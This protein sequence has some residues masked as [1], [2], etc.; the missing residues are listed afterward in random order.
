MLI[1][2][3]P[4]FEST[5]LYYLPGRLLKKVNSAVPRNSD[6]VRTLQ[7]RCVMSRLNG[8]VHGPICKYMQM[9]WMSS[10]Q[11]RGVFGMKA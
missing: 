3:I 2:A 10:L 11:R 6:F 5:Q 7:T 9:I 4:R 1:M 8:N